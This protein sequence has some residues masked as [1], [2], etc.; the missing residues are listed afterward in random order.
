MP[1]I[2]P[3]LE[4][5]LASQRIMRGADWMQRLDDLRKQRESG[6]FEI[7]KVVPGK[8]RGDAES[9]F[10]LVQN[11]YPLDTQQG[12]IPLGAVLD[13][14][15]DH[16][17]LSASDDELKEFDP[18]KALFVDTE[19]SGLAGGTG[20]VAFLVGVGY[21]V[22]EGFRLDQCFM[23]DYDDEEPMLAYLA[24]VF[25]GKDAVVSYNGKSFDLPLLR[26]RFIQNRIPFR[27]EGIQHFD[28]LHAAR[29]IWK[30]RLGACNLGNVERTVLG[31]E[32]HGDVPSYEIPQMWFDYLR[33]RDARRLEGVFYHHRM[34]ILSLVTLTAWIS[35][36]LSAPGGAGFEHSEDRLSVVR[37]YFLQRRYEDVLVHGERL[38]EVQGQGELRAECLELIAQAAKRLGDWQRMEDMLTLLLQENPKNLLA[39]LELAKYYEHRKRNLL[40]A[41]RMCAEAVEYLEMRAALGR[42]TEFEA[43]PLTA[44]QQRLA[45]IRRKLGRNRPAG[46][47][48][49]Q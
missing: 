36:C 24:E 18:R 12:S 33:S 31:I 29:R 45:R 22:E 17:A 28:L 4:I 13:V 40:D 44:F 8:L 21:F 43:A 35:Q 6:D 48:E 26:T 7:D 10:Y 2:N 32:R 19:T 11:T 20:T 16:I 9:G 25:R 5:L 42:A 23:R 14:S 47:E 15:G 34:D 27:L 37:V 3:K 30:R 38:I 49:G 1:E 39:R 41:E 46:D